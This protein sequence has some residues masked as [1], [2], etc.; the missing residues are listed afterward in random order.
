MKQEE[1]NGKSKGIT[2]ADI[3]QWYGISESGLRSR[4]QKKHLQIANRMLTED[5]VRLILSRLGKPCRMPPDL[6][7]F[8]FGT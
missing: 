2:R 5:D 6:Y 7:D 8:Y 1:E 4:M 3:A